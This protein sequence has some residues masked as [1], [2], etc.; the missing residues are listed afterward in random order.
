MQ[1]SISGKIKPYVRMTQRGKFVKPQAKEYLNSKSSIA[2]Q[3][4][5]QMVKRNWE[6]LPKQTPLQV[7]LFITQPKALHRADLDNIIKAVLDAAQGIVYPNDCWVDDI[8]SRR[9]L[10]AGRHGAMLEVRV[11]E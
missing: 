5:A 7:A 6:M 4:K 8:T 3:L 1:F 9:V 2:W 11:L 10:A